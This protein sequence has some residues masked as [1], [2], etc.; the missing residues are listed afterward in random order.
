MLSRSGLWS[1]MCKQMKGYSNMSEPQFNETMKLYDACDEIFGKYHGDEYFAK[2]D[3]ARKAFDDYL[4]GL[5]IKADFN[6]FMQLTE[7][8]QVVS[9]PYTDGCS[10]ERATERVLQMIEEAKSGKNEE[11]ITPF[12]WYGKYDYHVSATKGNDGLV[13][14][15]FSAEYRRCVNGHYYLL[16]DA[17]HAL[18]YE[19]D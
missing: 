10:K 8:R 5:G 6:H 18:Y 13:R 4:Y 15:W 7:Q 12:Y 3:E 14:A 19:D 16:L 11:K 1:D 9:V 2:M 17:T